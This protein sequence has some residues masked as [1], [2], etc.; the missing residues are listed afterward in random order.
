MRSK[1]FHLKQKAIT[2]RK[3]GYS[4]RDVES[5]LSIPRSTLSGWFQS[6]KLTVRQ[7]KNL[8]KRWR[9]TLEQA[10]TKAV[11]WHN[12]QKAARL[13]A[14]MNS[15]SKTIDELED[16]GEA[17]TELALAMLY[18]G[19]G[20]KTK[21]ETRLGN[22]SPMILKFFIESVMSLYSVPIEDFKCELHLRADQDPKVLK[23]FWSGQLNV[24]LKN[25]KSASIDMRTKGTPTYPNYKGV[26][27]VRCSR[28]AIQRKLMYI[29]RIFC[30]K[31]AEKHARLAQW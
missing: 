8:D 14:A 26:C 18:L 2:L 5:V 12:S 19:E 13:E 4:L 9:K 22:S 6:V 25:F 20:G 29:A 24:P 27:V 17:V 7:K 31:Y 16:L 11:L 3:K 23:K 30:E 10:R 15:A 21:S 1:W 28:V